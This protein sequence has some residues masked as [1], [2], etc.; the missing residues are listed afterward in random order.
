M[1]VYLYFKILIPFSNAHTRENNS[2]LLWMLFTP[3]P[4]II[5]L[6]TLTLLHTR[7]GVSNPWGLNL[8]MQI[9]KK[10]KIK[11][12]IIKKIKNTNMRCPFT[13]FY[14]W[15]GEPM[16]IKNYYVLYLITIVLQISNASLL[17]CKTPKK[18]HQHA[19]FDFLFWLPPRLVRHVKQK[20]LK[21]IPTIF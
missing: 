13:T 6:L 18:V 20:W 16:Q 12:T 19:L 11:S 4:Q 1:Q 21:S 5:P 3:M 17:Q 10:N 2:Y 15:F 7:Y 14:P 9:T 8:N